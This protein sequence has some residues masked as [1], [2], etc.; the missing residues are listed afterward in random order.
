MSFGEVC[1][2]LFYVCILLTSSGTEDVVAIT[3]LWT[4]SVV[5]V[6]LNISSYDQVNYVRIKSPGAFIASYF[7]KMPIDAP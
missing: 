2:S 1:I 7:A 6:S 5:L 4:V 3:I